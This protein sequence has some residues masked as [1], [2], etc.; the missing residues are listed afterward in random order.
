LK[1]E[2]TF[3]A[4]E[5]PKFINNLE[6]SSNFQHSNLFLEENLVT[7]HKYFPIF[8]EIQDRKPITWSFCDLHAH[9]TQARTLRSVNT[10]LSEWVPTTIWENL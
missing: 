3:Y 10:I 6:N 7:V 2:E 4:P 5:K 9:H 1:Q 8:K